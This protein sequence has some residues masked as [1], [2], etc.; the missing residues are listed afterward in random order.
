MDHLKQYQWWEFLSTSC[1]TGQGG[2]LHISGTGSYSSDFAAEKGQQQHGKIGLKVRKK[3]LQ[4]F[5]SNIYFRFLKYLSFYVVVWSLP[6]R[7]DGR[8]SSLVADLIFIFRSDLSSLWDPVWHSFSMMITLLLADSGA[9]CMMRT[10][11]IV[12][13]SFQFEEHMTSE[14]S[15]TFQKQL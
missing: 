4:Y 15:E 11:R 12:K 9:N 8:T 5:Y 13:C 1:G 6:L 14:R 3:V 7:F 10:R 2:G